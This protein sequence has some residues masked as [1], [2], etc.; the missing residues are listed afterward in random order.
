M[1]REVD[2][3]ESEPYTFNSDYLYPNSYN[4]YYPP[5]PYFMPDVNEIAEIFSQPPVTLEKSIE[6]QPKISGPSVAAEI[7]KKSNIEQV[8]KK[9]AIISNEAVQHN[10]TTVTGNNTDD[11]PTTAKVADAD[12]VTGDK[13]YIGITMKDLTE[14]FPI[15]NPENIFKG[16]K[17]ASLV[18]KGDGSSD[19]EENYRGSIDTDGDFFDLSIDRETFL[20]RA[21]DQKKSAF[22]LNLSK[23]F[24]DFVCGSDC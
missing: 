17:E 5:S 24:V 18:R 3:A 21:L 8:K 10:S 20:K 2:Y 14:P 4:F 9:E 7:V 15:N 23:Y 16:M 13:E 19:V 12:A 1:K 6:V 22:E 11:M